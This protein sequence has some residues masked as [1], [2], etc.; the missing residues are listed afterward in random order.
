MKDL[1]IYLISATTLFIIYVVANINHPKPVNWAETFSNK[2]KIPFGTYI[3]YNRAK[4]L[5][6]GAVITPQRQPIYN[7]LTDNAAKQA[8]YIII[9]YAINPSKTDYGQLVKYIKQGNDVF[10]AANSFGSL[11]EKNLGIDTKTNF[12]I[13]Q[14][15]TP[16]KFL[17]P[18]LQSP[19][20][21]LV[22]KGAGN[23]YF[24][25]LDTTKA[26][27]LGNNAN[28]MANF[29]KYRF[30]K[31]N[32][33]LMT[34][35]KMLS[36]Y[37]LLTPHGALYAATALSYVKNTRQIIWDEY[38][39]QGSGEAESPMRVFLNNP[40][41]QWA[42]YIAIFSLLGFVLFEIK[43]RQRI[44]PVIEPL[45]NSTL[46]FVTV[47]GQVYY[48]KHDNANI[49]HKKILYLL[50]HFREYYYLKTT[51]LDNE[52]ADILAQKTGI[53]GKFAIE[54]INTIN[55]ITVQTQ[56]TDIQLIQLNKLI[57][58]F[59]NQSGYNGK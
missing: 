24:N 44:I 18:A 49:A 47:V 55:F 22:D 54:L 46:D 29:I 13:Q 20:E 56:I 48:E 30:G 27:V 12:N 7:A 58:K 19:Q 23:Y 50:G 25:K 36:N 35:P 17:N 52:F 2:D 16:V 15:N 40:Q 34:N 28:K 10:I 14:E 59:Y 31:G 4:D 57:E 53:D 33:Y 5:F 6:P 43:R 41:L 32:L 45:A 38:Y 37:S 3:I 9:C 42:Y 8:S 39:T 11:V 21:Y 1:K 51:K 26:I